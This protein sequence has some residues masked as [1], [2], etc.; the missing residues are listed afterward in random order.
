MRRNWKIL[1]AALLM[2]FVL[3]FA[4]CGR[5]DT[6]PDPT[7][8]PAPTPAPVPLPPAPTPEPTPE[9]EPEPEPVVHVPLAPPAGYFWSLSRDEA[10]QGMTVGTIAAGSEL[11]GGGGDGPVYFL[12]PAGDPMFGIVET[13]WGTNGI[14]ISFRSENW[15]CLDIST[16]HIPFDFDSNAYLFSVTGRGNPGSWVNISGGDAGWNWLHDAVVQEDGRFFIS[17]VVS[18]ETMDATD[19]GRDQFMRVFRLQHEGHH[20]YAIYDI[21][22]TRVPHNHVF[23]LVRDIGL[24]NTPPGTMGTGSDIMGGAGSG[25]VPFL[26]SAGDPMYQVVETPLG[27]NGILITFRS[28]N[29]H[30]LDISTEHIPFDFENNAYY[31]VVYGSGNPGSWVNVSGGDAGWNWLHN[32][33]VGDDGRWVVH[34]V[35]SMDTMEGTDTGHE[36]FMRV[37]RIQHEGHHDYTV[38]DINI[39]RIPIPTATIYRL[40]HDENVQALSAG[41]MDT[42]GNLMG[43]DTLSPYLMSA[44]SDWMMEVID[45]PTGNIGFG[46]SFRDESW[47]AID[48]RAPH[49]DVGLMNIGTNDYFITVIGSTG[50]P[51]VTVLLGGADSPWNWIVSTSPMADGFFILQ[52]IIPADTDL[53]MSNFERAIRIQTSGGGNPDFRVYDAHIVRL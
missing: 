39:V 51:D 9:P 47:H 45:A 5:G 50:T 34:G 40:A 28:E 32:S 25:P 30:A 44:G 29:W 37:F 11:L 52:A 53:A 6:T 20:D 26:Q 14:E 33:T 49:P 7:P 15:H 48:L 12:Q 8:P 36:Q 46:A 1:L 23:S 13:P 43:Y 31:I 21:T 41:A 19:T 38:Y 17:G 42:A 4:A 27:H 16:E 10:V 18:W 22:I 3:A 35:I 2:A 24:Q